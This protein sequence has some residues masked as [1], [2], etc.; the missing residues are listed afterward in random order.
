MRLARLTFVVAV[1]AIASSAA[2]AQAQNDRPVTPAG[3]GIT[4]VGAEFGVSQLA[5]G[6]QGPLAETL[7]PD[8]GHLLTSSAGAARFNSVDLFDL[9]AHARQDA[10]QYDAEKGQ[11]AYN[12]VV[13]APDGRHAWASGGGQDVVHVLS[14]TDG[15]LSETGQIAT[16]FFPAGMAYGNTPLG[17]RIYVANNLSAHASNPAGNPAGGQVTVIDPATNQVTGTID[18]GANLQSVAVAF[19]R[20]GDKAYVTEWMGRSVAV[21]DT[22]TQTLLGRIELS[23]PEDPLQA[24]HPIAITANPARNEMYVSNAASDTVSI[25]NTETDSVAGTIDVS[26]VHD[27]PKGANPQGLDVTPDGSQLYVA[28]AGENA[29]ASVDLD[30]RS[31]NGFIPTSWYPSDVK[32]TPDGA[33]LVVLNTNNSGA[34][35]NPCGPLSPRSACPPK[36]PNRDATSRDSTDPQYSGSMIK[37]SVQVVDLVRAE[38]RL[39]LLTQAVRRNNQANGRELPKPAGLGAIKHV[40][41]VIKENRTYDQVLARIVHESV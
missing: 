32:V 17:D 8:G 28:L 22:R 3:W 2:S 35:P 25:I 37:G 12:G 36:D 4:P 9:R 24:D 29:V 31:V 18:L 23:P 21:I 20:S 33:R 34:G 6:F 27:G 14:V 19:D 16:P 5:T 38:R 26:L 10:I 11:A 7:T 15:R 13:V 41:Y 40:I 30:H 1:L 39:A